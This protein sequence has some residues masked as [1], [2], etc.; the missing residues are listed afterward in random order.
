MTLDSYLHALASALNH[1]AYLLCVAESCTGG[2]LSENI[3]AI[4][5]SSNW[6]DRGFITYS[7]AAK[8]QMLGVKTTTL[9]HFGAVSESTAIEMAEGA[10]QNSNSHISVAITGIAGPTGGSPEKPVGTVCFAWSIQK[11]QH[12][13]QKTIA[14]TQLFSGDR[15]AI[16]TQA[17]THAVVGLINL[18]KES[19]T[20]H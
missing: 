20:S 11:N 13:A 18:L 2:M 5:G 16:R 9:T 14:A 8:T 7:N 1:Q 3:T 19:T 12:H 10:L 15:N 6:F 4:A 17:T